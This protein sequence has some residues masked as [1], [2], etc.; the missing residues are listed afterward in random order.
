VKTRIPN[1]FDR[2]ARFDREVG[3]RKIISAR[4][5]VNVEALRLR[6]STGKE[7][8]CGNQAEDGATRERFHH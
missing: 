3:W 1:P 7:I 5:D 2:V 8:S 4:P 6:K